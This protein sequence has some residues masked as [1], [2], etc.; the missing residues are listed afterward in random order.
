MPP[1]WLIDGGALLD[2]PDPGPTP[3]LVENLIVDQAIVAAVGR[4]KTTKSYALLDVCISIAT[5]RPAFGSLDVPQSGPVVFVN[6][7]SGRTAL[8]RRLDSLCR[9]RGIRS[10]EIR[11]QL[12]LGANAHVRLDEDS[13]LKELVALG[14]SIEP[15]LFVFDPL[16]RMKRSDRD[17]SASKDMGA[18]IDFIRQLRDQT[19]AAVCYVHHTGH[20]GDHQRGTSDLESFWESKLTW[21][22]DGQ[23]K[24]VEVARE[25]REAEGNEPFRYALAWDAVTRTMR[26][27]AIEDS[28]RSENAHA[29][30]LAYLEENPGASGREVEQAVPGRATLIR[31]V[32]EQLESAGTTYRAASERRDA[33]GRTSTRKGWY[34]ASQ[35]P[36]HLVPPPGTHRD[37]ASPEETPRPVPLS[38]RGTRCLGTHRGEPDDDALRLA[39]L[40][41]LE[42]E[43][44]EDA[45]PEKRSDDDEPLLERSTFQQNVGASA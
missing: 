25:H 2:E 39:S 40:F 16:A 11:G 37:E 9:G 38:L 45:Y 4:W 24:I 21:K 31:K 23:S 35:A 12:H 10:D 34:L 14:Q 43:P 6:E 22:R 8:K 3:W 5:G 42:P 41:T 26:L 30:V 33:A 28:T 27:E 7:E 19:G 1:D 13:W 18:V 36:L 20:S 44:R 32:L 15:R 29:A 17:E